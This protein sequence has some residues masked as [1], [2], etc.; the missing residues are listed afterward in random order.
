VHELVLKIYA[1]CK[2]QDA[3]CFVLSLRR[4]CLCG[5]LSFSTYEFPINIIE[6]DYV[7]VF[8]EK[9]VILPV[10]QDDFTSWKH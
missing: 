3:G 5:E 10:R 4:E 6:R 2:S 9:A 7:A 1:C 8:V